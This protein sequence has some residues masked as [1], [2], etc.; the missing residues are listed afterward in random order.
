MPRIY[1]SPSTQEGNFYV[2]G[3]TEEYWMNQIANAMEP[4]LLSSGIQFTRNTPQM[5]AGSSITAS[6][7]GNYDLHLAIHS[8]AAP[9]SQAGQIMR[10]EVYYFPGST[11]GFQAASIIANNLRSIYPGVVVTMP[12]TRLGELRRVRAPSAYIEIAYHDNV[13]DANFIT[14]NIDE[15][16]ENIV[17]SLTEYFGI[18]FITPTPIREGVVSLT[19]GNL[20]IRGFPNTSSAIK[21]AVPNGAMVT[22]FGEYGE[23]Y[24]VSFGDLVGYA[25]RNFITIV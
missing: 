21:G 2:T 9:E 5:T 22:I 1:L 12:N 17:L 6:N 19:S 13:N 3:N 7:N 4:Y 25:N 18:P 11:A 20:N 8:N 23:W 14:N 15:I 16:A 24:V 10:S